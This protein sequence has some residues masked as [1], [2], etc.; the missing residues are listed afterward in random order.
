MTDAFFVRQ[1]RSEDVPAIADVQCNSFHEPSRLF[2][3]ALKQMFRVR[4]YNNLVL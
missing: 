2:D 1:L 4:S 3:S